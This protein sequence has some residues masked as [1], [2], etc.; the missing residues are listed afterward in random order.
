MVELV[1]GDTKLFLIDDI[2]ITVVAT[3]MRLKVRNRLSPVIEEKFK[4]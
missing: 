3:T 2:V 1:V 4:A